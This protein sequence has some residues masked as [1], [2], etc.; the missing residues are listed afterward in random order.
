MAGMIAKA[1]LGRIRGTHVG[2]RSG[3]VS[4]RQRKPPST[5]SVWPRTIS[6]SG[7][8]RN[9]T[10]P[11]MSSGVTI[12]PAGFREP[13]LEHLLAVREVVERPGLDDAR[14]DGVD[15]DPARRQLDGEVAHERLERSLRRADERVVLEHARR[16]EA[17]DR[18]RSRTL[19]ASTARPHAPAR[20]SAR[21]FASSVQSQCLS[22]VSSAGRITPVAALCTR[23]VER[24][25]LR[26]LSST[27]SE[28]TLPRTST[29]SAPSARSSSAVSSAAASERK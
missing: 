16:A 18:R 19:R 25:E 1:T 21:A 6:A 14:R 20:G 24:A 3:A 5:T 4:S 2:G 29:G 27:R 12:R 10:A 13:D 11:A 17:R 8:Q 15:A 22:S 7:E 23:H 28:V 26:D 9:A